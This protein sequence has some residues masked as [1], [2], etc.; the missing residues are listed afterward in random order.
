MDESV[1]KVLDGLHNKVD[2]KCE[3]LRRVRNRTELLAGIRALLEQNPAIKFIRAATGNLSYTFRKEHVSAG[4]IPVEDPEDARS[5]RW[6]ACPRDIQ[7]HHRPLSRLLDSLLNGECKLDVIFHLNAKCDD[8]E[9]LNGAIRMCCQRIR[10][11]Q[12]ERKRAFDS[13]IAT[14]IKE[15]ALE[16]LFAVNVQ[17]NLWDV[18]IFIPSRQIQIKTGNDRQKV[19]TWDAFK[20]CLYR[21]DS[22]ESTIMD[23]VLSG[24]CFNIR[25]EIQRSCNPGTL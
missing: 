3:S 23:K 17:E 9:R 5:C 14:A 20:E 4:D 6:E 24:E 22:V 11:D 1:K 21:D 25:S 15:N 8:I 7:P 10:S 16:V 2:Q 13:I 12:K 19:S 18:F